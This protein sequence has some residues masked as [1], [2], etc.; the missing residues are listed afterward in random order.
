MMKHMT[1]IM[2]VWVSGLVAMPLP[3]ETAPAPTRVE[4]TPQTIVITRGG[5]QPSQPGPAERFTGSVRVD[6]LFGSD[7][8]S[9]TSGAYVTF[10]RRART[11]WHTHPLGQTLIVTAGTGRVQSWGRSVEEIREGDVVRIPP[12]V[13]HWHGASPNMPM[14]HI[15]LT[16]AERGANAVWMEKVSDEQYGASVTTPPG[17]P[18]TGKIQQRNVEGRRLS[19]EDVRKVAPALE[20]YTQERL[21]GDLWKRPGLTPRDRSLVTIAAMVAGNEAPP[22]SYYSSEALGKRLC[23]HRGRAGGLRAARDRSR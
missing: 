3:V 12:G 11:A 23:R 14:T 21:Y 7:E 16:G 20:Q 19:P 17:N 6:P 15:A 1:A 18:G 5:S 22:L 2:S 4:R 9:G 8:P 13:K 10:E